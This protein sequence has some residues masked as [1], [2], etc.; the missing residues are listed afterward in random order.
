MSLETL[1]SLVL[2][3]SIALTVLAMGLDT[4]REEKLFLFHHSG[5]F[6][7]S[8]LAM[9]VVMPVAAMALAAAF[10][11]HPAVK[12]AL[13]AL[14]VSPVPPFAP[15]KQMKAGGRSAYAV[16]LLFATA[17]LAVITV[18]VAVA[19]VG[20]VAGVPMHVQ[21]IAV[22]KIVLATVLAPLSL[23]TLIHRLAPDF[24]ERATKPVGRVASVLLVASSLPLLVKAWP[25]MMSLVGNGTL[26]AL[27]V[28]AIVGLA[29]G[30]VLGGPEHEDRTVLALSTS[31]RHPGVAIAVSAAFPGQQLAVAAILL[32]L[33]VVG[34]LT[35]VYVAR[36]RHVPRHAGGEADV[37]PIN[38]LGAG[39]AN[40]GGVRGG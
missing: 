8:F 31:S 21:G 12:V 32:Y 1:V 10:D 30:H 24:A 39:R 26:V 7:R 22:G 27:I 18:P 2:Q 3:A 23:G 36:G 9:N 29:V 15:K 34:V 6:L 19:L 16:G 4:R 40:G 37:I 33:L 35:G 20:G 13:V 28:F 17:L 5:R 25:Q 14:A 38:I 11:F